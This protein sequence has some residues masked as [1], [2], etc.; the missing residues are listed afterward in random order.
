MRLP[1]IKDTIRACAAILRRY[2]TLLVSLLILVGLYAAAGFLLVPELIRSAVQDHVQQIGR[3]VTIGELAFN[4][5]S[6]ELRVSSF[7]LTEA[8]GDPLVAFEALQIDAQLASLWQRSVTLREV[9]LVAPDVDLVVLADG[10]VNLAQLATPDASPD[11]QPDALPRISLALLS[12]E[13]GRLAFT[14]QTRPKAFH[15]VLQPIQFVIRDFETEVDHYSQYKVSGTA[16]TGEKMKWSGG[17]SVQPLASNGSFSISSL[18]ATTLQ[19]YLQSSLPV[20]LVSG[21]ANLEG[22]YQLV[23]QPELSLEVTLPAVSINSLS[24]DGHDGKKNKRPPLEF[25]GIDF[26][27]VQLSL[28]NRKLSVGQ[29]LF[30]GARLEIE[31]DTG[32]L[33][34]LEHMFAPVKDN[35]EA[36]QPGSGNAS[37]KPDQGTRGTGGWQAAISNIQFAEGA[38]TFKDQ[39]VRPA[40]EFVLAPI[41]LIVEDFTTEA[42]SSS[43]LQADISINKNAQLAV[44][45]YLQWQPL[46]ARMDLDL[47]NFRLEATQPYLSQHTN[48]KLHSGL[49]SA[50]GTL[51]YSAKDDAEPQMTFK[52]GASITDLR[53]TDALTKNDIVSWQALKA[54]GMAVRTAPADIVVDRVE[55]RQPKTRVVIEADRSTNFSQI[56]KNAKVGPPVATDTTGSAQVPETGKMSV[57]IK[58]VSIVD[59]TTNFAD[60]SIE[61]QFAAAIQKLNGEILGLSSD[62]KTR[63]RVNLQGRVEKHAPVEITGEANLLALTKYSDVTLSL[64]NMDLPVFNP[65]SGRYAGYDIAKGKLNTKLRYR[66]KNRQL[67]A[68]HHVVLEQLEFGKATGSKEAVPLPV[69]LAAALLKDR[70]GV[71]DVQLPVGGNLDDP[72]FQVGAIVWE[73]IVNLLTKVVT[74]PFAALGALIGGGAELAYVDFAPGSASL[75]RAEAEKLGKLASALAERPQLKLDVPLTLASQVDQQA[76]AK[77]ALDRLVPPLDYTTASEAQKTDRLRALES[78]YVNLTNLHLIY[79]ELSGGSD[80]VALRQAKTSYL[81]KTLIDRLTPDAS[82][83]DRLAKE[84]AVAVQSA[85]LAHPEVTP[86][87]IFITTRTSNTLAEVGDVRMELKLE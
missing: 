9:R 40:A 43:K 38:V 41:S 60:L 32:G 72:K 47:G 63:A 69:R 29:L 76:L 59:G 11:D 78:S 25:T 67:Q 54:S 86:E 42:N 74:A 3:K 68:E 77:V 44:R 17:F 82:A 79:P 27:D 56:L 84:R 1:G 34:S 8:N 4:P 5:F 55:L 50:L 66:I 73:A 15:T 24:V 62:P 14:D 53:T 2:R 26:K 7:R 39:S 71:I 45:G 52:G 6:L 37:P 33:L 48:I 20:R 80:E 65:Y 16:T 70:K 30:T 58:A 46:K 35:T 49:L 64:R 13:N 22:Q 75:N 87:R 23:L 83:L 10:S 12:V 28:A 51:S 81:E 61:P 19:K 85:L 18:Q 57:Q 21:V 36:G 31:R